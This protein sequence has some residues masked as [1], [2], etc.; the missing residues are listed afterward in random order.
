MMEGRAGKHQT[1]KQGD[2]DRGWLAGQQSLKQA[3]FTRAMNIQV[4]TVYPVNSR[5]Y[6][7]LT[8]PVSTD[9]ADQCLIENF[10]DLLFVIAGFFGLRLS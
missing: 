4:I 9:V 7:R 1:I 2:A 8:M 10:T 5:L 6:Q 3:V